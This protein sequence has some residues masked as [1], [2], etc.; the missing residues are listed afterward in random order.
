MAAGP[1]LTPLSTVVVMHPEQWVSNSPHDVSNSLPSLFL[2][3]ILRL[4][5]R[6]QEELVAMEI[7]T[8]KAMGLTQLH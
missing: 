4:R 5:N 3:I 1:A 6:L 2:S 8:V 7:S